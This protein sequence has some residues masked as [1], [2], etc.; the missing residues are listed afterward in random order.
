MKPQTVQKILS[1]PE[2]QKLARKKATLGWTF[3]AMMFVIY[4]VYIATIGLYPEAF[5]IPVSEGATSTWGIYVG[6]FVIIFAFAITGIYV[7]KANGEFENTTQK[8]VRD[9]MGEI[10]E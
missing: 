6:V 5:G 8:V 10:N 9:V 2:F 7:Y 4:V 1:N 3:S